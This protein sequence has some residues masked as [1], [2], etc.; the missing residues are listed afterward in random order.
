M[1]YL[2]YN[3]KYFQDVETWIAFEPAILMK[4]ELR[5]RGV[6]G[7]VVR[8]KTR[9]VKANKKFGSLASCMRCVTAQNK[10]NKIHKGGS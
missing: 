7:D 10:V 2:T 4:I 5:L 9:R 6:T 8:L 3:K 1:L